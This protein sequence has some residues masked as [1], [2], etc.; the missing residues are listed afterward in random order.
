MSLLLHHVNISVKKII[1]IVR[2]WG[3]L[4][5]VLDSEK[6]DLLVDKAFQCIVIEINV[7][8]LNVRVFQGF[9]VHAEAMVLR[10]NLHLARCQVFHRLVA[11]PVTEFEFECL[12]SQG[13]PG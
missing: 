4:G 9:H 13:Q 7:A 10:C 2:T 12:S 1:G 3:C 6:R 8:Q 11:A 5:M